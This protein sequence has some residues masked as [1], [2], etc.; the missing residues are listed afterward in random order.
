MKKIYL[1][2]FLAILLITAFA[3]GASLYVLHEIA[4]TNFAY[5]V[6]T[7]PLGG[8]NTHKV[9]NTTPSL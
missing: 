8:H 7:A 1:N 3:G 6:H 5:G 9:K 4:A 2:P